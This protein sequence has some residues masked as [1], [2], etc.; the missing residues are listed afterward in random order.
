[1]KFPIADSYAEP[2]DTELLLSELEDEEL[3]ELALDSVSE[4][5]NDGSF[6]EDK[7]VEFLDERFSEDQELR[8]SG[9]QRLKL[10]II[11]SL[12]E[13]CDRSTYGQRLKEAAKK[14]GK[15]ERTV[16]RL[17]KAWENAGLA[18]LSQ[19]PRADK[20][21]P[22]KSEYWYNLAVKTYKAGNKGSDRMTRTQVAETV[23][24]K[25]YEL[26]K[27]ELQPEIEQ[28]VDRGLRGAELDWE[29]TK[30]IESRIRTYNWQSKNYSQRLKDSLIEA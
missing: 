4:S 28:L 25:A 16:R 1:V 12:R 29:I 6:E 19:S 8:L 14:L 30:L 3:F 17:I 9:D 2:D 10:E 20:R 7:A 23:K 21:Q 27:Q 11:R 18:A 22:R 15:S 5:E 24:T 26:A 13:P